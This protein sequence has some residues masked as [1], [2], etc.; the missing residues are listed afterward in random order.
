MFFFVLLVHQICAKNSGGELQRKHLNTFSIQAI[1]HLFSYQI[2]YFLYYRH[3]IIVSMEVVAIRK[4]YV[5]LEPNKQTKFYIN[6]IKKEIKRFYMFM[7]IK[8]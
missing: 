5:Q 8:L 2:H 1:Y 4:Y 7:K 6:N 3:F